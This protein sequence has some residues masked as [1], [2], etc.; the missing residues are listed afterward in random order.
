MGV[1]VSL[2]GLGSAGKGVVCF[3]SFFEAGRDVGRGLERVDSGDG[4]GE[5]P[6]PAAMVCFRREGLIDVAAH[7]P[8]LPGHGTAYRYETVETVVRS[9]YL[10]RA[11]SLELG[12]WG[13]RPLSPSFSF[14]V[15]GVPLLLHGLPPRPEGGWGYRSE[16]RIQTGSYDNWCGTIAEVEAPAK[17]TS[18]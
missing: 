13:L 1:R 7:H 4:T 3:R 17:L 12:Q 11:G 15:S 14:P 10:G 18:T 16:R 9:R 2:A 8:P 5:S 6:G